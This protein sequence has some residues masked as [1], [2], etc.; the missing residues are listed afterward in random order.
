MFTT[1]RHVTSHPTHESI[2]YQS[3]YWAHDIR[4]D[5][6]DI[7]FSV[8]E[9]NRTKALSHVKQASSFFSFL[10][11]TSVTA[12]IPAIVLYIVMPSAV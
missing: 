5:I 4:L 9:A 12:Y 6:L 1:I 2:L 11:F 8:Y 7:R 10:T 3:H